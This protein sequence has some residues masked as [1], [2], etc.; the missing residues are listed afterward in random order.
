M[1]SLYHLL[2]YL[3]SWIKKAKN[4]RVIN[5]SDLLNQLSDS[6]PNFYR[7]DL[8]KLINI[9]LENI[10]NSLRKGYRVELRDI[11]ILEAK[12]YKAKYARNPKTNEKVYVPEKRIVKFK[13]SLKWAKLINNEE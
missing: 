2:T 7:R 10:R 13:S 11:F 5:K 8:D 6:F 12:K 9:T 4:K 1:E 3:R